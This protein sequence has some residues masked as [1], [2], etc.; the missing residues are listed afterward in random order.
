MR[1]LL[2]QVNSCAAIKILIFK[3]FLE[4]TDGDEHLK[5]KW[6]ADTFH[7]PGKHFSYRQWLNNFAEI[8]KSGTDGRQL[9]LSNVYFKAKFIAKNLVGS[10]KN[11]ITT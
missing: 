4:I 1:N 5:T 2:E 6:M 11:M 8:E 9:L 7:T 10:N 3:K